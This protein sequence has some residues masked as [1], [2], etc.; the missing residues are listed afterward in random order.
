MSGRLRVL[1]LLACMMVLIPF[2]LVTWAFVT[3]GSRAPLWL[4]DA[5]AMLQFHVTLAVIPAF[6]LVV[7]LLAFLVSL[8]LRAPWGPRLVGILAILFG[9]TSAMEKLA[10]PAILFS[11]NFPV[12]SLLIAMP[13]TLAPLFF[14][15]AF[16]AYLN[17]AE[18]AQRWFRCKPVSRA[19][20][21][22]T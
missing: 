16:H 6:F 7:L 11:G 17:D 3:M 22:A 19:A 2:S 12:A 21:T 15:V 4:V 13:G 10:V 20:T 8:V 14:A 1:T 9:T 18:D 5:I